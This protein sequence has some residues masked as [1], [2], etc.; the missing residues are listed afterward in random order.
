L[1]CRV[2]SRR[3]ESIV[4]SDSLNSVGSDSAV[5]AGVRVQPSLGLD[6]DSCATSVTL[7]SYE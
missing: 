1:L 4:I 6:P 5:E 3:D 7:V 2:N